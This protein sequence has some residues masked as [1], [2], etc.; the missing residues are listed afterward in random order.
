MVLKVLGTL[1]EAEGSEIELALYT[2]ALINV[3]IAQAKNEKEEEK[4]AKKE[5]DAMAEI[6]NM[7]FN[8]LLKRE[9]GEDDEKE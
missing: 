5:A 6:L 3:F 4:N 7:T 1:L 8:E 9:Q 2:H